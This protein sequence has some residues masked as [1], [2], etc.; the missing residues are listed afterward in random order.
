MFGITR[1]AAL[2]GVTAVLCTGL[3]GGAALAAFAP[4]ATPSFSIDGTTGTV[5]MSDTKAD[6]LKTILDGLASKGVITQAQEDA[7]LAAVKDARGDDTVL[8]RVVAG[9]LQESAHYLGFNQ[10]ELRAR[11]PGTSLGALADKTNGKSRDGLI[12]DLV[13]FA[14]NTVDKLL[15][16]G[17]ITQDQANKAKAAI[18]DRVTK[19]VD[20]V[21]PKTQPKPQPR[22]SVGAFIGDLAK[23]A[24][25]YLGLSQ[26]DLT[27]QLRSGKSLGQIANATAGKSRQG[28]I[29]T[30]VKDANGRID[31]AVQQGKL[32]QAQADQLKT[33]VQ[34]AVTTLVDRTGGRAPKATN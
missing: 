4:T 9:L 19:F 18:P 26:Q 25:D 8:R 16:D 7:I 32:T 11:L 1:K 28:L 33:K 6:A 34:A 24:R 13:T 15:A 21:W 22:T 14:N 23:D 12:A 20:H 30:L 31:Q 29:D 2:V 5:T 17:K 3:L 10:Q 27:T